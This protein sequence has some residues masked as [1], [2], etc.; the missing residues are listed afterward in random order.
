MDVPVLLSVNRALE[1]VKVSPDD[2]PE[3]AECVRSLTSLA[4]QLKSSKD[5]CEKLLTEAM[6]D[7]SEGK[8]DMCRGICIEIV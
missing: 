3:K 7:R 6:H 4:T 8:P 5:D 1:E 2:E